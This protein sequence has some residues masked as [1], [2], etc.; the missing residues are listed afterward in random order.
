MRGLK[1]MQAPNLATYVGRLLHALEGATFKDTYLD[2]ITTPS[3]LS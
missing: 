3:I 1:R 2:S